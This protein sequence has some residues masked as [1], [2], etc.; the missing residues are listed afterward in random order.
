M[1][2]LINMLQD[3]CNTIETVVDVPWEVEDD[4]I[5]L[6]VLTDEEVRRIH[7]FRVHLIDEYILYYDS[8][9]KQ[10]PVGCLG[11]PRDVPSKVW[12]TYEQM[13][14][15]AEG[16]RLILEQ[17]LREIFGPYQGLEVRKGFQVV[18]WSTEARPQY[19]NMYE[20][21]FTDDEDGAD[22]EL[23]FIF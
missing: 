1:A 19:E 18:T 10:Y 22:A 7:T 17:G 13:L 15:R 2:H 3:F 21:E 11:I 8:I 6:G 9:C 23:V 14:H 4:E 12:D 5:V 16:A 20:D